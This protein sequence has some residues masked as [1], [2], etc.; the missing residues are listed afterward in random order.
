MHEGSVRVKVRD[1]VDR[2]RK[3]LNAGLGHPFICLFLVYNIVALVVVVLI[4]VMLLS[5]GRASC[6]CDV[7]VGV[8]FFFFF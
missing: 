3:R 8:C 2:K 1:R 7:V 4:S 5:A 6:I